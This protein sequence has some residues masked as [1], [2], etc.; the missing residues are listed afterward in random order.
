MHTFIH[1]C[2]HAQVYTHAHAIEGPS[3]TSCAGMGHTCMHTYMCNVF[4][5]VGSLHACGY[6][7]FQWLCVCGCMLCSVAQSRPQF[8]GPWSLSSTVPGLTDSVTPPPRSPFR[9]RS[10]SLGPCGPSVK[11][12]GVQPWLILRRLGVLWSFC[13]G[14]KSAV[15]GRQPSRSTFCGSAVYQTG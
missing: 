6:L 5:S 14:P 2:T 9:S 13:S 12:R 15:K 8:R 3:I 1:T 7:W 10:P 4:T 11:G